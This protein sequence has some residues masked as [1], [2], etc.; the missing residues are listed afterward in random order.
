MSSPIAKTASAVLI[1]LLLAALLFVQFSATNH[2]LTTRHA[3]CPQHGEV[4]DLDGGDAAQNASTVAPQTTQLSGIRDS[5]SERHH[6][7]CLFV[8]SRGIRNIFKVTK[9]QGIQ[10]AKTAQH[11]VRARAELPHP[12]GALYLSAPKHSPP[13]A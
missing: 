12:S 10:L 3:I 2:D 7:H 5:S 11:V 8:S 9:P 4:V 13:S 6:Q 1:V